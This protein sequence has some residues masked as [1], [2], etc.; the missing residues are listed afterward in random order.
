MVN[1]VGL[2]FARGSRKLRQSRG[3]DHTGGWAA[4]IVFFIAMSRTSRPTYT[5]TATIS[6]RSFGWTRCLWQSIWA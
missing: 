2:L 6:R 3:A 5:W 4:S 1:E